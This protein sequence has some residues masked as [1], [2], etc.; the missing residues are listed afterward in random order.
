MHRISLTGYSYDELLQLA[1]DLRS[2]LERNRRVKEVDIHGT[3][4]W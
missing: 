2:R 3:G 4:S 1:K